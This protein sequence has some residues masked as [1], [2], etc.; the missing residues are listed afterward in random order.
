MPKASTSREKLNRGSLRKVKPRPGDT[1]R[2][3]GRILRGHELQLLERRYQVWTLRKDG[4]TIREIAQTLGFSEAS[5]R[6]DIITIAK[7]ISSE[8]AETVEESRTLQVARLDALLV[9]Y[10]KLAEGGNMGAATLVLSIEQR[11]SKLLALDLPEN[12][13]L[14]VT[15]I[16]EYVGI[17]LDDV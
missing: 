5:I 16:R 8:L 14:E 4:N 17:N 3:T 1:G 15:G 11:R 12:K 2:G 9:K 13:K 10:Q 7:R 6:D